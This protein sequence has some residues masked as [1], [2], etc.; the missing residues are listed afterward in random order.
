M[1]VDALHS[2]SFS[3]MPAQDTMS[4]PNDKMV[5]P[6]ETMD[7]SQYYVI[8]RTG[9]LTPFDAKKIVIAMTK[10]F[11]EVE[12]YSAT[13]STRIKNTV[14]DLT[15]RVVNNLKRQ[16][17][18]AGKVHIE[19]IQDQ[20]EL[21][22]M[23]AGEHKVARAYVLY[24][25]K[26]AQQRAVQPHKTLIN[27]TDNQGML[28]PLNEQRLQH[29][30]S[31]ACRGFSTVSI[32]KI[33]DESLK[34]L[35]D[36]ISE[37]DLSNALVMSTRALIEKEPDYSYVAARLLLDILRKEAF[38]V[39]DIGL[40][41][42]TASEM[43]L[44]YPDYFQ[45]YI[46]VGIQ[47]Q[48]IDPKLAEFDLERLGNA[49]IAENDFKFTYLGLQTLYDRYFLHWQDARFELPQ[50]FFMRV[51]MGLAIN[52][53]DRETRA[54][55]FYRLL[56][57]FDFMCSTPTLFN[58]GTL[59]PQL[60]SCF[61]STIPDDLEGIF[62]AIK[63]NA[64]LQKWAGG[65]GNDWTPVRG[66]GSRIRGTNG[67]SQGVVPFMKVANDTL[68]SVNQCFAPDTL[69]F[70]A[71]GVKA[72]QQIKRGDLVLAQRGQ[73]REVLEN[74]AYLHSQDPMLTL[75]VKHSIKPLTVS[76]GH[77]F[78][79]LQGV[80]VGQSI[81]ETLAALEADKVQA[82]W[83]EVG[84]L[85]VGDYVAQVIPQEVIPV[86]E[87]TEED[88]RL[89]GILL[90]D[91]HC[92][93]A[94]HE[95]GVS[96]NPSQD[97]HLAF[98]RD[99]LT[100]RGIHFW[101][102]QRNERYL[103]IRWANSQA[104]QRDATTGQFVGAG[105]P[106]L[107]FSYSDLYNAEGEKRI[108]RR[109]AHLPKAQTLAMLQGLIE[110]DGGISRGKEIYF[111]TTSTSLAEGVRYQ[112]LRLG[113]ATAGQWFENNYTVALPETLKIGQ[114][115]T[116]DSYFI[117]HNYLFTRVRSIEATASLPVIHDLK[118]EGDESYMT[119]AALVHN[120]GKRKG[121]GCAYLETW[122]LDIEEFLELRKNTG[123]ERRRTHDMN[124]ANWTPDLFMERVIENREWTLFS[125]D[126]FRDHEVTVISLEGENGEVLEIPI[127]QTLQVLRAG[128]TISVL[129]GDLQE[130]DEIMWE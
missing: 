99:Y 7:L 92:T 34:N 121:S 58:S 103:Q 124:T 26:H 39:V 5:T 46:H 62:G 123:D 128:E 125:P 57:S 108:A 53:I 127:N 42:A 109:F 87:F 40:E 23:R 24:R 82:D 89:Y 113:I 95:W 72:I 120:G 22:L 129:A 8:R 76:A 88:A 100:Q 84:Q 17:N 50:A 48:L 114:V 112:C 74:Y 31:E 85:Q 70:T 122:H 19:D 45:R 91:G 15:T 66:M 6:F 97:S 68:V 61:L 18:N 3:E 75:E 98:V 10:A 47:Y 32:D 86:A 71:D 43:A 28:K 93:Q 35:Y 37:R 117:Y 106:N 54:I 79:S 69:V 14:I 130:E 80:P 63:D 111:T 55:E 59:R 78:F 101:E 1:Q 30:V 51:A 41:E 115:A 118:V 56:S 33:I 64:L 77:P 104:V 2:D 52:E 27:I 96:D 4:N 38:T 83:V 119:T 60:S 105:A 107:P 67:K 44:H 110:T 13:S 12:G 116:D 90:G 9:Q 126:E 16:L 94:T 21:E 36:G 20:V 29:L 73:Y 65:I 11:L 25:E 49:L 81:Q 102:T